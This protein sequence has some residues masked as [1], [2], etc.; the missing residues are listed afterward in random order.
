VRWDGFDHDA[1][2]LRCTCK[3][4][5]DGEDVPEVRGINVTAD[6]FM[7]VIV[8]R[9]L[10]VARLFALATWVG[11]DVDMEEEGASVCT[12]LLLLARL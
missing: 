5:C 8:W 3:S 1:D 2:V 10:N 12:L 6:C 9:L 7:I 11:L 4:G